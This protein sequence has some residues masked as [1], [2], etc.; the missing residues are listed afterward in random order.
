[1]VG[2]FHGA[3]FSLSLK[4]DGTSEHLGKSAY[5]QRVEAIYKF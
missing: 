2:F 3:L 4:E 5:T 1:M